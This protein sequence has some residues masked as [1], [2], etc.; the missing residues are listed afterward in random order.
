MDANYDG[1]MQISSSFYASREIGFAY[2]YDSSW[3]KTDYESWSWTPPTVQ[4]SFNSGALEVDFTLRPKV[5][6][7]IAL[8]FASVAALNAVASVSLTPAV[9]SE[10]V[11]SFLQHQ[12]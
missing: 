8:S 3:S 7:T 2:N 5:E 10:L 12:F 1:S 11:S 6:F 9:H 4:H